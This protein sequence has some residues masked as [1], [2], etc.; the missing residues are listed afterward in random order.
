VPINDFRPAT[1]HKSSSTCGHAT[2]CIYIYIHKHRSMSRTRPITT[3]SSC[4]VN[5]VH[6]ELRIQVLRLVP[7]DD[8]EG[9]GDLDEAGAAHG[10]GA[11]LDAARGAAGRSAGH[12][13]HAGQRVPRA[14][15]RR[16]P[17]GRSRRRRRPPHPRRVRR[18]PLG[19]V[20]G[21]GVVRENLPA[22]RAR[23]SAELL[24]VIRDGN[25]MN[26]IYTTYVRPPRAYIMACHAYELKRCPS[27]HGRSSSASLS[28][29]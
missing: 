18:R 11:P 3:T 9:A 23:A 21:A 13:A 1:T 5:C 8:E 7:L 27:V 19:V 2:L 26:C 22:V 16:R 4:Y 15:R 24:S 10:G 29:T 25:Q 14:D 28:A 17:Q 12:R 20:A 6:G